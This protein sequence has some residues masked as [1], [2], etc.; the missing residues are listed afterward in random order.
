[1]APRESRA[2]NMAALSAATNKA[3]AEGEKRRKEYIRALKEQKYEA[4]SISP[5]YIPYFGR[6]MTVT[7]NGASIAIPCDGRTYKI[8]AAFAEEVKC[9]IYRQDE[10][11]TKKRKLSDV[12]NN[13]EASPG[14]LHI[15]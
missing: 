3:V 4:V 13:L 8:P 14:E 10:L 12:T 1:M 11:F 5:L 7:I 2:V 15:F 9:R 6:I